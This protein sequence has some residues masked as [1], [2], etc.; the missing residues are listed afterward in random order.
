MKNILLATTGTSPQVLTETLFAIHQSGRPFPDEVF[1]ITTQGAKPSLV[2]GLFRDGHL[3]ALKAE[4]NLPEFLFDDSHIWLIE[5][6]QGND[7]DD[8]KS[9]EDQTSMADFITRKVFEL[10]Q[11]EACAIHASLAGGR[12]TMAFYF[13][14]AMSMF[15]REQDVLSHVFVDDAFEFVRDFWFPTKQSKWI[16]GKNGQG[17]LDTSLATITLAEIPF[18]RMRKSLDPS[19]ISAMANYSFSQ[20]VAM[21][22]ASYKHDV[23]VVISKSSLLISVLGIDI[24]LTAKDM[25]CYLWLYNKGQIGLKVD[26]DFEDNTRLSHEFLCCYAELASDPRVFERFHTTPED[27]REGNVTSITGMPKEFLQPI[28]SN[29]N[30]KLK[31]ALPND[32]SSKLLIESE[33]KGSDHY[34]R[35]ALTQLSHQ[36]TIVD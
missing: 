34:Y 17:E 2:N 16:T 33:S 19:L 36:P 26:R 28:C 32:I 21:L 11:D 29:I 12:K 30:N 14:Y 15:G 35:V 10:T 20:T 18:V 6:E 5:D 25:A 22:N 27:F 31:K 23:D 13:G 1:V 8:A 3:A 7:I 4:Y 9:V 24:K